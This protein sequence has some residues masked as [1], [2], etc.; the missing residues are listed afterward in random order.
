M[1][2]PC[3]MSATCLKQENTHSS[4]K[5]NTNLLIIAINTPLE[6]FE[7]TVEDVYTQSTNISLHKLA[8]QKFVTLLNATRIYH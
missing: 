7:V 8:V 1:K 4:A 2:S 6:T 3:T 5:C